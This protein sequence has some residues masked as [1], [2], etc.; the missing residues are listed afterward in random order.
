MAE[1]DKDKEEAERKAREFAAAHPAPR[2]FVVPGNDLTGY[3]GVSPEYMNY[4]DPTN[5]PYVT[6]E[7]AYLYTDLSNQQVFDSRDRDY[8]SKQEKPAV[9]EDTGY[10]FKADEERRKEAERKSE[11][12]KMQ[13]EG[14]DPEVAAGTKTQEVDPGVVPAAGQTV[15]RPPLGGTPASQK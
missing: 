15:T 11:D 9:A 7:E 5:K 6:E 4:A 3:I 10:D 8:E 12:E 13:D 2:S 1:N 14:V